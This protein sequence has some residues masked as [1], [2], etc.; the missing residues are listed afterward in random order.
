MKKNVLISGAVVLVVAVSVVGVTI[1]IS[2]SV[3]DLKAEIDNQQVD[4]ILASAE[5]DDETIVAVPITYY[6]QVMDECVNINSTTEVEKRQFE[7]TGCKYYNKKLEKKLTEPILSE[8]NLPI[9]REGKLLSNRGLGEGGNRWFHTVDGK[10]KVYGAMLNLNYNSSTVTFSYNSNEFYPLNDV[11]IPNELVNRDGKNHLFTMNLALPVTVMADGNESFEIK[12]DDDTWVYIDKKIVL[13]MG[14][15]HGAIS[16]R[17]EINKDGEVYTGVG[18]ES[19]AY[20]GVKLDKGAQMVIRI[21]HADRDSYDSKFSL[22][23]SNMLLNIMSTNLAKKND[24][25]DST[26]VVAVANVSNNSVPGGS[27]SDDSAYAVPLGESTTSHPDKS[28]IVLTSIMAQAGIMVALVV[29]VMVGVLV[30]RRQI[31]H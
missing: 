23:F 2:N 11:T 15:V 18:K 8:E 5:V 19:L 24:D 10:S 28:R 16:G 27:V 21:F 12:A 30:V 14:G 6:D 26:K 4:A 7:W 9:L 13:D 20:A 25:S 22:K 3:K 1:S 29:V 31:K 17:F